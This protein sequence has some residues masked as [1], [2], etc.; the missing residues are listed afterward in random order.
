MKQF[1]YCEI[2]EG[3]MDYFVVSAADELRHLRSW[4][5]EGCA[6]EDKLLALWM[7]GAD[8]GE[9]YNHRLG[10]CIRLKDK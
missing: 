8:I 5:K 6:V 4:M 2:Q 10:V 3:G 9:F 1:L 7:V